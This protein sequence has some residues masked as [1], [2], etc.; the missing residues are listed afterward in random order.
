MYRNAYSKLKPKYIVHIGRYTNRVLQAATQSNVNAQ[1]VIRKSFDKM[2]KATDISGSLGISISRDEIK[3]LLHVKQKVHNIP[4]LHNIFLT[5][6]TRFTSGLCALFAFV[7]H[8]IIVGNG[9]S[10][11]K[12]FLKIGVNHTGR[13]WGG[14]ADGDGPGA[15]FFYTGGEV[16]VQS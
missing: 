5:F 16:G 11:D 4:I 12:A 3:D 7:F 6:L 1:A 15:D 2:K 13:L 14:C 8:K 9:F 10:A